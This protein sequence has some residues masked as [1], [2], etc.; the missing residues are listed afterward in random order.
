M[1]RTKLVAHKVRCG[2]FNRPSMAWWARV[3]HGIQWSR[4]RDLDADL[5]SNSWT[6]VTQNEHLCAI[7]TPRTVLSKQ[8]QMPCAKEELITYMIMRSRSVCHGGCLCRHRDILTALTTIVAR[9]GQPFSRSFGSGGFFRGLFGASHGDRFETTGVTMTRILCVIVMATATPASATPEAGVAICVVVCLEPFSFF[10]PLPLPLG[11]PA[12]PIKTAH[13]R[14]SIRARPSTLAARWHT[15]TPALVAGV[16]P[17][18]S[19][20]GSAPR[21]QHS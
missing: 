5:T 3:D 2:F 14:T 16:G 7:E 17:G 11:G 1:E 13:S 12:R 6:T 9:V 4:H 18:H 19:Q 20:P 8:N 21:R 15:L 10:R